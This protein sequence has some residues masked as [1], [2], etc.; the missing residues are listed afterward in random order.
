M[1]ISKRPGRPS[2][3]AASISKAAIYACAMDIIKEDSVDALSFR[4]LAR[5]LGVT[6]MTVSYH[7][8][9][10]DQ[11]IA[12]LIAQHFTDIATVVPDGTPG[13]KLRFLLLR[14]CE[15]ALANSSLV[16]CMLRD[17][18]QMPE[19]ILHLTKLIRCETQT[20]N[21]G[22][23]GDVM[24]NLVVDYV[25]GFVFAAAAAPPHVKLTTDDCARSLDWL[26]GIIR[27][28]AS[29]SS[30]MTVAPINTC[31]QPPPTGSTKKT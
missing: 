27:A 7:V 28:K 10:R 1:K 22:D 9:S 17:P 31:Q 23:E 15:A 14:Y 30:D 19:A 12:E 26:L 6:P 16:R 21:E 18:N 3:Q 13:Q 25:H 24:L 5:R 4:I 20:L 8:G 2:K 11:M 29:S